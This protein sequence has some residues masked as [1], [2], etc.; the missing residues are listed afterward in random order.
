MKPLAGKTAVV[1]GG[2]SGI[3]QAFAVRLARDGAN[4]AVADVNPAVETKNLVE[5]EGAVFLGRTCDASRPSDV[6]AFA[7]AVAEK[8][9]GA[10]ILVNNVGIYS[11]IPFSDLT[12]E[13]WKMY[14]SINVDSLF[15]FSKAFVPFMREKRFGRIVNMSS[16]VN[17]LMLPEYT[18]YITTKAAGIGFTRGLANELGKDGITV[19]AIAPSLVRTATTEASASTDLF[20]TIARLQAIPRSQVPADLVGALA[21]LV[22]E[23]AAFMTGQTLVVDGGMVK[24]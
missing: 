4:V 15:L 24:H 16:T 12:F 2:A 1:T 10:E 13:K 18:H 14:N 17:W 21:F 19:N 5:I 22:S 8:F 9:G 23:D 11:Y 20:E 7:Q 6:S 3:G